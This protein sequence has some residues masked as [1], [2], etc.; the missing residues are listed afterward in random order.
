MEPA[1]N[2][3]RIDLFGALGYWRGH[4]VPTD[5]KNPVKPHVFVQIKKNKDMKVKWG[6]IFH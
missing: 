3:I 6:L 2:P 1:F 4:N 5:I